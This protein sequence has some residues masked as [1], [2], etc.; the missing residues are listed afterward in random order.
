M[1]ALIFV[2]CVYFRL[3]I[4]IVLLCVYRIYSWHLRCTRSCILGCYVTKEAMWWI[5]VKWYTLPVESNGHES[6]DWCVD[7]DSLKEGCGFA[8]E[9]TESP[10]CIKSNIE[11]T[12][13]LRTGIGVSLTHSLVNNCSQRCSDCIVRTVAPPTDWSVDA[14]LTEQQLDHL[15]YLFRQ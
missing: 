9:C 11:H 14:T 10:A 6:V 5:R 13:W 1:V 7:R 12:L 15:R 4:F 2:H 3:C 8:H